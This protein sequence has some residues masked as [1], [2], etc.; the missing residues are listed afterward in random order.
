[1]AYSSLWTIFSVISCCREVGNVEFC[2]DI[3]CFINMGHSSPTSRRGLIKWRDWCELE[4]NLLT[5]CENM[6]IFI[7]WH[8]QYK[9]SL[10]PIQQYETKSGYGHPSLC[11][12]LLTKLKNYTCSMQEDKSACVC[13]CV[14]VCVY[15]FFSSNNCVVIRYSPIRTCLYSESYIPTNALLYTIIY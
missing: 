13:V 5:F 12:R 14:C 10:N 4:L 3:K 9:I 2:F 11:K 1:M 7:V 15:I 6:L 8:W